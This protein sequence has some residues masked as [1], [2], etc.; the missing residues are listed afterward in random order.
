MHVGRQR[1][2]KSEFEAE[3]TLEIFG[4]TLGDSLDIEEMKRLGECQVFLQD[5]I[6]F[7]DVFRIRQDTAAGFKSY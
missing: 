7:I 5:P 3:V 4:D 6:A 1:L 2:G